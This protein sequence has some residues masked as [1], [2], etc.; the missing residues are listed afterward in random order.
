MC[1]RRRNGPE[2]SG[3]RR[4]IEAKGLTKAF[5]GRRVVEGLSFSIPD[6]GIMALLG[7][8]G[9]G[10]TTTVRMLAC[11][12][13]PTGGEATVAGLSVR[14]DQEAIRRKVGV[15]TE[16]PGLY[17]R[18]TVERYLTFFARLYRVPAHRI[19]ERL[20]RLLKLFGLAEERNRPV[21][22]FS[23]GMKQKVALAR[24]LIHDPEVLF[25]D[26]PTSGLDPESTKIVRDYILE[27]KEEKRRTILLCTHNLDEA[28]RLSDQVGIIS[29]GRLIR[30][31]STRELQGG[32]DG[33]REFRLR[34]SNG[35]ERFVD[36]AGSVPGVLGAQL[37]TE[38]GASAL[39]F[40]TNSPESI[41]AQVLLRLL[42]HGANVV[43]CQEITR[44]LEEVYLEAMRKG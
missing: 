42:E 32:K 23:K 16:S 6:G 17:D 4:L 21:G 36:L 13:E 5:G 11:L 12:L 44:S 22:G 35:S 37:V 26:E 19:R 34:I 38:N 43:A 31:G 27:L 25:L 28:E 30:L 41:N 3:V 33:L 24:T 40:S 8:N 7:P 14:K 2:V 29:A 39:Q 1:L 20:E 18:M 15:L 9:A 10:K